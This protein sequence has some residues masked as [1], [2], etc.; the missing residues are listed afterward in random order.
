MRLVLNRDDCHSPHP[1]LHRPRLFAHISLSPLP[2]CLPALFF[3]RPSMLCCWS[4]AFFV[5][6]SASNLPWSLLCPFWPSISFIEMMMMR[7]MTMTRRRR[8][9]GPPFPCCVDVRGKRGACHHLRWQ[10]LRW[11]LLL[12]AVT[13]KC[14]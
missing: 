6:F 5:I 12:R 11:S 14:G 9:Y 8:C 2:P 7:M 3:S 13:H 10:Q 4:P 1:R